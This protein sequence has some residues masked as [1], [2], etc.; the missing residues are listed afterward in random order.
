MFVVMKVNAIMCVK[1]ERA[2]MPYDYSMY[3][4]LTLFM[5]SYVS[6]N[7]FILVRV[8]VDGILGTLGAKQKY[9]S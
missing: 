3:C 7:H 6:S 1:V 2:Y 8:M 4:R 9:P 5:H